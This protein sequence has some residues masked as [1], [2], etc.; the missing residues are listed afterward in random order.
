ME[1]WKSEAKNE[2]DALRG[3]D[4][5][6]K[7][8]TKEHLEAKITSSESDIESNNQKDVS[9]SSEDLSSSEDESSDDLS[10]AKSVESDKKTQVMFH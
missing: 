8:E 10:D 5:E 4:V 3:K 7:E 2:L 1:K 9:A 6:D